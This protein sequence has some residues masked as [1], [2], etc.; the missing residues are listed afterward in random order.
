MD[1]TLTLPFAKPIE[2]GGLSYAQVAL[3]EPTAGDLTQTD[4]LD[5]YAADVRLVSVIGA[6]PEAAVR[7]IPARE[8]LRA[9]R[10]IGGF[11]KPAPATG[12]AA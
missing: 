3:R 7:L 2:H 5:G 1:E 4:G 11:L 8:F 9:T 12:A 10:F 6:M